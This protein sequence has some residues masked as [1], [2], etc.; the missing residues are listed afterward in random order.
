M[1]FVTL[2]AG[3]AE[4]I[5]AFLSG[6]GLEG[7]VRIDLRFVG[8]CDPSLGLEVD[9]VRETD[10]VQEAEGLTFVISPETYTLA[11]DVTI[12]CADDGERSGFVLASSRPVSE[13]EGF[14]VCSIRK[15]EED[16]GE[17]PPSS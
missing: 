14:G 6:Q 10:L 2:T 16:Q 12:S 7:P 1:S 8:C 11:G 5:K 17:A 3:A 13:W 4:A 9:T 15:R